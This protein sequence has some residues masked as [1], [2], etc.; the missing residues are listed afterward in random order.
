LVRAAKAGDVEAIRLLLEKHADP[1]VSTADG[2][3]P[4]MAAAGVGSR[5]TDTRGR[6]KS[7]K[8]A[9]GSIKLLL[10]GGA[11]LNVADNRGQTAL[12]GAAF[13]G[14]NELVQFL[15]DRGA[16]LDAKDR[17]GMTPIDSAMGRAG[18]NG[19]GGNRIDVHEDTAAL[20]KKLLGSNAP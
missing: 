6:Y 4:V 15:A 3:T 13:W 16:K 1:N 17:R 14:W 19:F 7:E 11:Q 8:D 9:I 18:G 12:H 2:I 10:E 20:L 5:D